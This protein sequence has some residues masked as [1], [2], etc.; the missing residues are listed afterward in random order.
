MMRLFAK[1]LLNAVISRSIDYVTQQEHENIFKKLTMYC[2]Q[3]N[4]K[5]PKIR[6][7]LR[8]L[9]NNKFLPYISLFNPV[10]RLEYDD[11]TPV[12]TSS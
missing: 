12:V 9:R 2:S 7:I 6:C 10:I 5:I 11:H 8:Y 3:K 1:S 4:T